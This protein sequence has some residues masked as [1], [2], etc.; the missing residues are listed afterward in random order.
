[1]EGIK[2]FENG[3]KTAQMQGVRVLGKLARIDGVP[4][5]RG[6]AKLGATAHFKT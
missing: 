6:T 1:M 3:M 4:C 5:G 2:H